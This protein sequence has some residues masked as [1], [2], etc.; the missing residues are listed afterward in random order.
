MFVN[1]GENVVFDHELLGLGE[2]GECN[3]KICYRSIMFSPV[4]I[5]TTL[6]F[7]GNLSLYK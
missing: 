5:L 4:M 1:L 6:F 3:E 7:I 2:M